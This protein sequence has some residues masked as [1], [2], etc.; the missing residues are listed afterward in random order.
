MSGPQDTD[1]VFMTRENVG[2][3]G[4]ACLK[5]IALMKFLL[6]IFRKEAYAI[7]HLDI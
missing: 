6:L 7:N 5:T 1:I 4:T 3:Y 2:S